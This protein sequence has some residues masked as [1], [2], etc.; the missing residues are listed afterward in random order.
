MYICVCVRVC[1]NMKCMTDDSWFIMI[2]S[3]MFGLFPYIIYKWKVAGAVV[4]K[5]CGSEKHTVTIHAII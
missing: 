2:S 3:C 4:A 5:F 1:N